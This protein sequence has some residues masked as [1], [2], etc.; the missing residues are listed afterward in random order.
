MMTPDRWR[1]VEELY[2]AASDRPAEDRAVLL[3]EA[4]AGDEDLRRE[5]EELLEQSDDPESLLDRP[6]RPLLD[7]AELQPGHT[8]GPYRVLELIGSGGM[9]RVYKALDTRL[10]RTVA[11]KISRAGFTGRFRREARAVAALNHPH[12]CTL[13]DLGPNYLVMEYVEGSPIKG[14]LALPQA[15]KVAIAIADA[16][17]CAHR[18]G[19]V[20][21]DLKPANIL[22]TESGPKLLDFGLAKLESAPAIPESITW[23]STSQATI[24]GTMQYMAPE[25]LQG[26]GADVRS[27][28]FSL[29]LI[30][31]EMLTGR[32]AFEADNTASLI[33]AVLT[34]HPHAR[35][36]LPNLA[37]DLERVLDRALAKDPEN[38]WQSARDLKAALELIAAPAPPPP[39]S[40]RQRRAPWILAG[41]FASI[42]AVLAW[43]QWGAALL[44]VPADDIVTK[45][46]LEPQLISFDRTV[47][48]LGSIG[49]PADYSN[50]AFSPDGKRL[51]VAIRDS[52]RRRDIWVFDIATGART[53]L[54]T[55]PADE[56]NP[57]WSPDG[58]EIAYCSARLGVRDIY[59]RP[60]GGGPERLLHASN[61]N[62]NPLDWSRDGNA[63]YYNVDRPQG[64]H[65]I[66]VLPIGDDDK[67]PS[68]LLRTG[69]NRDWVAI[70]PD[71][72]LMLFR[73]GGHPGNRTLLRALAPGSPEFPIGAAS[74]TEGHWRKDSRE[75]YY[76]SDGKMVAQ[77]VRTSGSE[78]VLGKAV[79]LFR[80]PPPN[81]FGR[82]FLTVSPDGRRFVMRVGP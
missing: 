3:A 9:G 61:V 14:P 71:S 43:M 50:P 65:D 54:S 7:H 15:L 22:L 5:V 67:K 69:D 35:L 59:V 45:T 33:A 13:Y 21:R 82:N 68:I 42:A 16:L 53:A 25:Q 30:L 32:P 77:E 39:V 19:V 47:R 76:V 10:G 34:S 52:S 28:I 80:V 23:T 12:I 72:R 6:A 81:T 20:H 17:D 70:S 18:K 38:R 4:C 73:A 55:D 24:A 63:I 75:L 44:P 29:G 11:I 46:P 79:D 66:W 1:T 62:K 74:V 58:S 78:A 49:G 40:D 37:P 36:H 31:F 51:A 64:G 57:V 2:H 56:T 8:L 41:V 60:S 48:F 27:D 26:R